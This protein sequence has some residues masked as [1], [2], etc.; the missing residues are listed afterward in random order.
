[1]G[2]EVGRNRLRW[3][4]QEKVQKIR[5]ISLTYQRREEKVRS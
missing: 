5:K 2:R 4:E 3:K 1:M